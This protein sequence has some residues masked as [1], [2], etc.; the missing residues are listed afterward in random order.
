LESH[1][2][3]TVTRDDG[4]IFPVSMKAQ[5]ILSLLLK[6]C[7]KNSVDIKYNAQVKSISHNGTGFNVYTENEKYIAESFVIAAGGSSYPA[8]GS[9]GDGFRLAASLGHSTT[10]ITTALAPLY[11]KDYKMGDLSGISVKESRII[12]SRDNKKIISGNGDI[13]FTPKGLSGPGILDFSRYARNGDR[14]TIS[15][16]EK[17]LEEIESLLQEILKSEGKKTI[18]NILKIFEIPERLID[19]LLAYAS[20]NPSKRAGEISRTE[21]NCIISLI[22]AFPFEIESKGDFRVAMATAGGVIREE[23]DRKTMQSKII[24]GLYFAGEVIDVDGDTGGYNIQWAFSSG[25][26]AGECIKNT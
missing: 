9:S 20:I 21:R 26:A 6:L 17:R 11:L 5:D 24:K 7:G 18:R 13:L 16:T 22:S 15:L 8:T 4:K 2:I 19:S 12:I 3:K 10:E 23:I 1:G 25:K 14:I